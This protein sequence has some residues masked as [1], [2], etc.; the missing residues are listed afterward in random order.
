MNEL[1]FEQQVRLTAAQVAGQMALEE[2]RTAHEIEESR[3]I[4]AFRAYYEPLY[5]L[6]LDEAWHQVIQK[7]A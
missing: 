2:C 3:F 7:G 4:D 6:L 5:L 1:P